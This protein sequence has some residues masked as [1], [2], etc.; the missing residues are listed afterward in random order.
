VKTLLSLA[1]AAVA[2]ALLVGGAVGAASAV[3]A[4]T[5]AVLAKKRCKIVV[6]KIHG[7]KRKVRV[8]RTVKLP[9]PPPPQPPPP[10]PPSPPAPLT[11]TGGLHSISA[12][13][14][15]G[16]SVGSAIGFGR[17]WVRAGAE[18]F[19]FDGATGSLTADITGLPG[20][21]PNFFQAVA[22]GEGAVWTSNIA[23]GS[24]SRIDPSTNA[25]VATIPVWPT[26]T[27]CFG[28]A[29]TTCSAPTGIAITPGAVWV[30]L[31]HEWKVARID[32]ATN[33]VVA[34]VSLGAGSAGAGPSHVVGVGASV[35]AVGNDPTTHTRLL[36]RIDPGATTASTV[37]EL[38]DGFGCDDEAA[39]GEHVWFALR[40]CDGASVSDTDS[41]TGAVV[42][43]VDVGGAPFA[44]ES[45]AGAIWV[46]TSRS[47]L[48]RID[49]ASHAI[50]GRLSVP[51]G[52][53]ELT[54]DEQA[55]WLA[56]PNVL[57]RIST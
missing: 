36:L 22:A 44:I 32:P 21:P 1:V 24:V 14:Y 51:A 29:S 12:I 40:G 3:P 25:I 18:I 43:T 6:K 37:A 56:T 13:P 42:G 38:P 47:E 5:P 30:A 50:T 2:A 16:T 57:Y 15:T 4:K 35:Y 39:L 19:G 52:P 8:C 20:S 17:V 26:N 33:K 41:G 45:G 46:T 49:P 23:G 28:D 10:P 7:K 31:H 48:L 27:G 53:T 54:A 9:P 34:T 11:G 55:V